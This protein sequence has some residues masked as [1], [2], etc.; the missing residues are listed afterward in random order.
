M[1]T[2]RNITGYR[3][4]LDY[5]NPNINIETIDNILNNVEIRIEKVK[6]EFKEPFKS[7]LEGVIKPFKDKVEYILLDDFIYIKLT[8]DDITLP[9]RKNISF[10]VPYINDKIH[11]SD[12][13]LF[14]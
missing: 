4:S 10:E 3:V 12:T 8:N 9:Y 5:Y 13:N 2:T 6:L 14:E 11:I 7:Y 1:K